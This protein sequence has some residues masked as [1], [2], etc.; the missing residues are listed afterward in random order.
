M[1][2]DTVT[3]VPGNRHK[4]ELSQVKRHQVTFGEKGTDKSGGTHSKENTYGIVR[5]QSAWPTKAFSSAQ[6]SRS[7]V[8]DSLRL[9]GPRHARPPCPSPRC[10]T[11]RA[12]SNSCPLSHP[13]ISSSV[14]PFPSKNFRICD[15]NSMCWWEQ[16]NHL[17]FPNSPSSI[18]VQLFHLVKPDD[19]LRIA[20]G[21]NIKSGLFK[22][23]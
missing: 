19:V 16:Q 17:P 23:M 22:W 21:I 20:W 11:P 9:Q 8:S 12:Y 4:P 18:N 10:P 3:N 6:F 7:V 13:T 15:F 1:E 5:S 2:R 14:V